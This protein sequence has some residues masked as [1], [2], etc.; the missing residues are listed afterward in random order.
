MDPNNSSRQ[1][2]HLPETRW[3]NQSVD[4]IYLQYGADDSTLDIT[5][6]SEA[7]YSASRVG[8]TAALVPSEAPTK[9]TGGGIGNSGTTRPLDISRYA[10][11]S[12]A[13]GHTQAQHKKSESATP[14]MPTFSGSDDPHDDRALYEPHISRSP[15]KK[16]DDD[17]SLYSLEEEDEDTRAQR[18]ANVD[19]NLSKIY[20]LY[21]RDSSTT[22]AQSRSSYLPRLPFQRTSRHQ[23]DDSDFSM[24]SQVTLV[25][26]QG[27]YAPSQVTLVPTLSHIDTVD[28]EKGKYGMR[29]DAGDLN[30]KPLPP[31]PPTPT[32]KRVLRR[33]GV[34]TG[35]CCFTLLIV[36]VAGAVVY[37]MLAVNSN[38]DSWGHRVAVLPMGV[39]N[40]QQNMAASEAAKAAKAAA[41]TTATKMRGGF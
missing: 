40:P 1:S 10:P 22:T 25:P 24:S 4:S 36:I 16:H 12:A 15:D 26:G 5:G 29:G 32:Q 19:R 13:Q 37:M 35:L 14:L 21:R 27:T 38:L 33:A 18:Q 11:K 31:T 39:G 23:R 34:C 30:F 7:L 28:L 3:S 2:R 8:S 17:P 41:T 6:S 9:P 20:S